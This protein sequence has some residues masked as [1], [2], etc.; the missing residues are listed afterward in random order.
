MAG[1][2]GP[3]P[4]SIPWGT[5]PANQPRRP[6]VEEMSGMIFSNAVYYPNYRVYDGE[7]PA[8]MNYECISH[9]FYAFA[10]VSPDGGVFVSSPIFVSFEHQADSSS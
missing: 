1:R 4:P 9:V 3:A 10:N 7:T 5:R 6:S 8:S 2:F